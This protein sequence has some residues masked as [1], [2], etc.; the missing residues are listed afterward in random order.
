MVI[1]ELEGI[2]K[3]FELWV[4]LGICPDCGGDL[5]ENEQCPGW[6]GEESLP[7]RN[8]KEL[9][10]DIPLFVKLR[11]CINCDV[12]KSHKEKKGSEYGYPGHED[13]LPC[14]LSCMKHGHAIYKPF[15]DPEEAMR[16]ARKPGNEEYLEIARNYVSEVKRKF[17]KFYEI[18]GINL[19]SILPK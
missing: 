5:D 16:F 17:G 3:P 4:E 15:I 10:D 11:G 8:L 2:K 7:S 18:M 14:L 19:N 1:H 12:S 6:Y 9:T 13:I